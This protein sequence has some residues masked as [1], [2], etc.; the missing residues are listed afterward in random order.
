MTPQWLCNA[1]AEMLGGRA[2]W[3]TNYSHNWHPGWVLAHTWR[4]CG[5]DVMTA[6]CAPVA[7]RGRFA[8]GAAGYISKHR[9]PVF[10]TGASSHTHTTYRG[11]NC[12]GSGHRL[13]L[14][15]VISS[16]LVPLASAS[17]PGSVAVCVNKATTTSSST[18]W[19]AAQR[20]HAPA[21]TTASGRTNPHSTMR[22]R[23]PHG[24]PNNAHTGSE[25]RR[26]PRTT[27][28]PSTYCP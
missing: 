10:H 8:L 25:T 5:H 19:A 23:Q 16:H 12:A 28:R 2:G 26:A 15:L 13:V 3:E 24:F 11:S 6:G 1:V 22:N 4:R 27:T 14:A 7:V 21:T 18:I 9:T 17:L 20:R